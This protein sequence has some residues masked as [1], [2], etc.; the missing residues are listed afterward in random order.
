MA[1]YQR[2]RSLILTTVQL[3]S[4]FLLF[5]FSFNEGPKNILLVFPHFLK[6][7]G[8]RREAIFCSFAT[9][10][11]HLCPVTGFQFS[12]CIKCL[13]YSV[14]IRRNQDNR[15]N[16]RNVCLLICLRIF[17]TQYSYYLLYGKQWRIVLVLFKK[18]SVV[19]VRNHHRLMLSN[20]STPKVQYSLEGS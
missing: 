5:F 8:Q 19:I 12:Y 6:V 9:V 2:K 14:P 20:K 4:L 7:G 11:F 16:I 17:Y 3:D 18:I 1:S 15:S 13:P 10:L